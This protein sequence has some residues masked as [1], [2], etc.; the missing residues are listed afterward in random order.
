MDDL[1]LRPITF[2]VF[3]GAVRL[4][5]IERYSWSDGSSAPVLR[6]CARMDGHYKD[7]FLTQEEALDWFRERVKLLPPV[8][9]RWSQ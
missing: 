1:T 7:S 6:W 8:R 2:E 5:T 4:G 9:G 3:Q